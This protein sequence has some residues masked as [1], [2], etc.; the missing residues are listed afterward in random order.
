MK[1]VV[2]RTKAIKVGHPLDPTTMI[3]AQASEE[4]YEKIQKYLKIGADEGATVLTG[5]KAAKAVDGGFYIE[6]TIFKG[7]NK[8]RVFQEEIFG[9]VV[10]SC[11]F[12]TTDEAIEIANDTIY[13]LGAGVFTRDAHEMYQL[14]RAIQVGRRVPLLLL[15]LFFFTL[16]FAFID[17]H[18]YRH[19]C[20]L[21]SSP[22]LPL[23]HCLD[24]RFAEMATVCHTF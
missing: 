8:M 13:G 12:K 14:P 23:I 24:H 5:G 2:E 19:R 4:Q 10:S 11:T 18:S 16:I 3:G 20:D 9:P 17:A 21:L 6:P 7:H 1:R 15:L 22:C